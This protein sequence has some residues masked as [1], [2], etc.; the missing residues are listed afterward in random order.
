MPLTKN[1]LVIMTIT[2]EMYQMADYISKKRKL[3]EYP[4]EGYG[5]YDS[6][7]ISKIKAGLLGELSFFEFIFSYLEK[8]YGDIKAKDRWEILHK[9]I[10]FTYNITI[11]D[12]DEGFEFKISDKTIDI[13]T[14]ENNIVTVDQIF[15]GI[16]NNGSPL[17]LFID[18]SQNLKSDYY[19]Q[20]FLMP[21][22]KIC[23][24]G[25]SDGLPPLATWM[26]KPAY[27]CPVPNLI[28]I[29]CLLEK[30]KNA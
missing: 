16:R 18:K 24:A 1:D 14:Y 4:R 6:R 8:K 23:L 13:K 19:V 20:S 15:N 7:G 17:N 26:P 25:Y 22:N 11:G 2:E 27:A 21:E 9:K 10:K 3:F 12:F 30:I 5:D 29:N 28:N